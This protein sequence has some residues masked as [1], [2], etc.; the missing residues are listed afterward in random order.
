[1]QSWHL[2]QVNVAQ[3]KGPLDH[4]VLETFVARIDEMNAV[5]DQSP[6]FV[7]RLIEDSSDASYVRPFEDP[8][9][10]F[11]VSVWESPEAL[12]EYVYKSKHVEMIR[13]RHQWVLDEDGSWNVMWWIPQGRLPS[14]EEA[15]ERLAHFQARGATPFAFD[16][17]NVFP[18]EP[19]SCE[20][21]ESSSG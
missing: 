18:P 15:K 1:M 12:R 16:F 9:I 21:V 14:V 13:D 3:M 7:W 19:L 4:P 6:G 5:A 2:A 8:T 11:N 17:Q 20:N 10:L